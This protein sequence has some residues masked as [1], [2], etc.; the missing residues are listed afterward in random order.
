MLMT[1]LLSH[2]S[3][4]ATEKTSARRDVDAELC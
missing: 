1:V 4:G 2:V 3:D